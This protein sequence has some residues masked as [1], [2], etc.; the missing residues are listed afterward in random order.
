MK[1]KKLVYYFLIIAISLTSFLP[2]VNLSFTYKNNKINLQSFSKKQL[3]S[4]D[5]I[6]A[7]RNYFVYKAFNISLNTPQVIAGKDKFLFLGN[8][9]ASVIDKTNGSFLYTNKD[10]DIWT[11][12]L[13]EVQ[14]WHEER[15]IKFI[16]IVASNKHTIYDDKLPSKIQY[17]EDKTIT[18]DIMRLAQDK[19]IHML[20]LKS[21]LRNEKTN[22]Q[23]YIYTDTH[24]TNYGA[25][26]G[27]K[28]T[29]QYLN[30]I[31]KTAYKIPEYNLTTTT[32][33]GGDLAS[34][35]KINQLLPKDYDVNYNFLFETTN[36]VCHGKL[37]KAHTLKKC[38][39]TN[40]PIMG[41]NGTDQY[42]INKNSLNK[43][44]LL[45]LC[46]SFGTANS[47]P[48]NETFNTIWKFHYGHISG[49]ALSD[50]VL[51]HKPDIVI[52]QIVE[53]ALFNWGIVKKLAEITSFSESN[54]NIL[55]KNIFDINNSKYKFFKN[56]QFH[57]ENKKLI[58]TQNDPIIILDKLSTNSK[59][60]NLKVNIQ[61]PIDTR[62]QLFY[63]ENE[64]EPYKEKNS[65]SVGIK[66]GDNLI[67]LI[68]P[69]KYIKN[70]LRIE[71]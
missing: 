66:K 50:F 40:N 24:W 68:I 15:G 56:N 55:E 7:I 38:S 14:D 20:N 48:Y 53:R 11:N 54:K 10:I 31:Y 62:F 67:N 23:L 5:N 58:V 64:K 34:F 57:I 63:K 45:L 12:K 71:A 3:F 28:N 46:D 61:S 16:V 2:I 30:S 17:K 26:I 22:K 41:I 44:K 39:I 4:T 33:G 6:E 43:E 37:T 21:F 52:Y 51:E 60:V 18:D 9:Y 13:K 1:E 59:F 35:L 49:N 8:N 65:Y 36:K 42:M 32:K 47:Q 70:K 25:S 27:F 29:I 69:S 19:N